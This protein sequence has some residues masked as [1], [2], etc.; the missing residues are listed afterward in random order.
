M[1]TIGYG[2][3]DLRNA[4]E[5]ARLSVP[6]VS[7]WSV[8]MHVHHCCLAMIEIWQALVASTPP[9]PRSRRSFWTWVV[10]LSGHIPRGR[11][12]SPQVAL[13]KH[14]VSDA[15]LLSLLDRCQQ[16]AADVRKLDPG[17]W[18]RHVAL[19]VLNRDKAFK[20]IRIHNRHHLRIIADMVGPDGRKSW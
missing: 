18:F 20:F 17:T 16:I 3:D 2:L 14:D 19:G 11:Q 4:L 13:P 9:P 7:D 8:A 15:E 6:A 10:F 12:R 5:H 1:R